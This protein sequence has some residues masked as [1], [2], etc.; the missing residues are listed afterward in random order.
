MKNLPFIKFGA[1]P[2]K[3]TLYFGHANAYPPEAYQSLIDP[4]LV[5]HQVFSYLQR[6]LWQPSPHINTIKSW[7]D[8]ADDVIRFFD[9]Q[10]LRNVIGVGHSLGA[11]TS[12]LAAQKRPDLFKALVMT[13]CFSCR[14]LAAVLRNSVQQTRTHAAIVAR[15]C[16]NSLR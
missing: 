4:L 8:L 16:A 14:S 5:D 15:R 6:G 7:H 10:G 2:A 3:P 13:R 11:V 9:Q 1:D 12:F